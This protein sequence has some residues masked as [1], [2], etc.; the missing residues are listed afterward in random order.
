MGLFISDY[1]RPTAV[2]APTEYQ[3]RMPLSQCGRAL[4][5]A[6]DKVILQFGDARPG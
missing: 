4:K 6:Q 1:R 2:L 5:E 3:G